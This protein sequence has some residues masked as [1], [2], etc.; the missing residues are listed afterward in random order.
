MSTSIISNRGGTLKSN[1]YDA[2]AQQDVTAGAT[3]DILTLSEM[4]FKQLTATAGSATVSTTPFG[5]DPS[6][7]QDGKIIG[8]VNVH[9][10]NTV[11][12]GVNDIQ[13][14]FVADADIVLAEGEFYQVMYNSTLE[15]FVPLL[16]PGGVDLTNIDTDVTPISD[17]TGSVGTT[18]RTWNEMHS[19]SNFSESYSIDSLGTISA[20]FGTRIQIDTIPLANVDTPDIRLNTGAVSGFAGDTGNINLLTG[21]NTAA[22]ATANSGNIFL[23]S[24]AAT[25]ANT[26]TVTVTT[27]QTSSTAA[28]TGAV[29]V[30]SGNTTVGN[31]GTLTLSTGDT[32]DAGLVKQSGNI[33]I[34]SGD[35]NSAS[36]GISG[37]I[38]LT[39]GAAVNRGTITLDSGINGPRLADQPDGA[40]ALAIATTQYADSKGL[41]YFEEVDG[42]AN[43]YYLRS[44]DQTTIASTHTQFLTGNVT[45]AGNTVSSGVAVLATG[46]NSS[47]ST[48]TSGYLLITSGNT[49]GSG[50]S[51]SMNIRTG[52]SATGTSG[53]MNIYT[54]AAQTT[55]ASSGVVYINSG[56]GV[57][58]GNSGDVVLKSG[59]TNDLTSGSFTGGLFLQTGYTDAANGTVGSIEIST[60]SSIGDNALGGNVTL[61]TGNMSGT[62]ATDGA[63][64]FQD[65]SQGTIGHVWTSTGVNGEGNWAEAAG[66]G[67][68]FF[69]VNQTTHGFAVGDGIYHNGTNWV[70][71]QADDSAT[72]AYYCVSEVADVDNFTAA[73]FGRAT[74]TAHGFTIGEFYFL[75]ETVAGQPTT[76][77]P[78]IGFS[79]PLFFVEDANTLQIK[80]YRP[81]AV[82]GGITLDQINDVSAP[83]PTEGQVLTWDSGNTRWESKDV[84]TVITNLSDLSATVTGGFTDATGTW[85]LEVQG[86][87]V[88]VTFSLNAGSTGGAP[89]GDLVMAGV[90]PLAYRPAHNISAGASVVDTSQDTIAFGYVDTAGDLRATLRDFTGGGFVAGPFAAGGGF[91]G[92]VSYVID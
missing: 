39:T 71:G 7:F 91:S 38:T 54:G 63:I 24:G 19:V 53:G 81:D 60:G 89:A 86:K 42:G 28:F 80:V 2:Q 12:L 57:S 30:G 35:A 88:T 15:R 72:L 79:N 83:T 59:N 77:E 46:D 51:G 56:N 49:S 25:T 43:G 6:K 23:S 16:A 92:S 36:A 34:T 84:A 62:G 31:T 52:T 5:T 47:T 40:V 11:T 58:V 69:D 18:G 3:I 68:T 75:S 20:P 26:G 4:Q 37:N 33:D 10:T 21:N 13:Y 82:G 22:S 14:G 61:K 44:P 64:R 8:L 76:T 85:R 74:A 67:G 9:A 32:A 90:V 27:G 65:G 78:A 70:K 50:N 87:V 1:G 41:Q 45:D 48:G 29:S 66:G 73:D 17:N 55:G